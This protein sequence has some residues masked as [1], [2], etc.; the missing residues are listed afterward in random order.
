MLGSHGG[1]TLGKDVRHKWAS[2]TWRWWAYAGPSSCW[3]PAIR[4]RCTPCAGGHPEYVG[5]V[6][7]RS[8]RV[9]LPQIYPMGECPFGDWAGQHRSPGDDLTII[10][11]GIM[12]AA[13]LDAV[14][15]LSREGHQARAGYAGPAADGYDG[16][17]AAPGRPGAIVTARSIC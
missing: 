2:K 6:W 8:S 3:C 1:I 12:V 13:A 5:P 4:R 17:V 16:H 14:A 10:A 11:C 15:V 9:A 7:L